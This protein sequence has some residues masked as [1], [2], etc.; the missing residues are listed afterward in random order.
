MLETFVRS[1]WLFC[2]LTIVAGCTDSGVGSGTRPE[3][4]DFLP[5]A[6]DT[7]ES[8]PEQP[9]LLLR[10]EAGRLGAY[11]VVATPADLESGRAEE[12]AVPVK[13]DS[14]LSC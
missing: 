14:V 5:T 10:C 3:T 6:A 2:C 9:Q 7:L 12:R 13:L 1:A 8:S 11:M 4:A